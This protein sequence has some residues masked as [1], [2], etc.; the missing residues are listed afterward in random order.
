MRKIL[1]LYP[2]EFLC[3]SKLKRKLLNIMSDIESYIIFQHDYNGFLALFF[4]ENPKII[5]GIFKYQTLSFDNITHSIIFSDG[6]VFCNEQDMLKQKNIPFRHI[7]IKI[8]RVVNINKESIYKTFKNN[9]NYE[10]IGRGS[11][12][13]NLYHQY[14]HGET[15]ESV[16]SKCRYDFEHDLLPNLTKKDFLKLSGK[17]LGCFCH[18]LPCH[19][20]IYADFLN[21]YDDG[22]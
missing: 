15:R 8:T 3:Y 4:K 18:P 2:K 7:K 13:G 21:A 12:W 14:E 10:Y 19:G 9:D 20:D 22:I 16:I 11:S 5:K 6:N 1:I 17:T